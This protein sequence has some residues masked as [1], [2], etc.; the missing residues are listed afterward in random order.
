MRESDYKKKQQKEVDRNFEIFQE[1][2]KNNEIE[3]EFY[4]KFALMKDGKIVDYFNTWSDAKKAGQLAY[5]E[6]SIFSIQEV[7]NDSINLGFYSYAVI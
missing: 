7:T 1:K 6:D 3:Q 5:K 4:G 2:M